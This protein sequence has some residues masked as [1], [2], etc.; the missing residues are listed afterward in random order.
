MIYYKITLIE[1]AEVI[2]H[3]EASN[4]EE[5]VTK[6]KHGDGV[7][8]DAI[9]IGNPNDKVK[10]EILDKNICDDCGDSF[11]S[12]RPWKLEPDIKLCQ[13]CHEQRVNE[14]NLEETYE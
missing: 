5:A 7:F 8:I 4:E 14:L 1:Q 10:L 6:A 13:D 3:V 12:L 2:Y 11:N 9:L